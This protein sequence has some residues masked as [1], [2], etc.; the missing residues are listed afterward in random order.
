MSGIFDDVK[1][2][3]LE[4]QASSMNITEPTGD[5]FHEGVDESVLSDMSDLADSGIADDD[6]Q[7]GGL[8]SEIIGDISILGGVGYEDLED[9]DLDD[10]EDD[11]IDDEEFFKE[12]EDEEDEDDDFEEVIRE[13]VMD[14]DEQLLDEAFDEVV[15]SNIEQEDAELEQ[16]IEEACNKKAKCEE[17]D[18]LMDDDDVEDVMD[19]EDDIF[20]EDFEI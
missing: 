2:E 12:E 11:D 8:S 13:D 18:D 14:L 16:M 3:L 19:D 7:D 17:D 6:A 9:D 15:L 1:K 4:E 10:E 5:I 20:D